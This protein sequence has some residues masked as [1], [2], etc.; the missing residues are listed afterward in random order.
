M[1]PEDEKLLDETVEEV[2]NDNQVDAAYAVYQQYRPA[3]LEVLS[4]RGHRPTGNEQIDH[5]IILIQT[6]ACC[7]EES[8]FE[9]SQ[10]GTGLAEAAIGC[11]ISLTLSAEERESVYR[12][13]KAAKAIRA[14]NENRNENPGVSR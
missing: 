8:P 1:T 14:A 3:A 6:L 4:K 5:A 7:V 13:V 11:L 9:A 10:H 2:A 12:K